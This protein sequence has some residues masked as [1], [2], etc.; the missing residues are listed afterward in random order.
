[1]WCAAGAPLAL[2]AAAGW[3]N[4][5]PMTVPLKLDA[6]ACNPQMQIR[7]SGSPQQVCYNWQ[8]G[9]VV[10]GSLASAQGF[11]NLVRPCRCICIAPRPGACFPCPFKT[12][13]AA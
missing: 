11:F 2:P 1:M 6:P 8:A 5:L 4:A 10:S 7:V 12:V 13:A 9:Q 3:Q